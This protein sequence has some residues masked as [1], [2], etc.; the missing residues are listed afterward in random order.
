MTSEC[1]AGRRGKELDSGRSEDENF[2]SGIHIVIPTIGDIYSSC[3]CHYRLYESADY[4]PYSPRVTNKFSNR[5]I[6]RDKALSRFDNGAAELA[7]ELLAAEFAAAEST[8]ERIPIIIFISSIRC[9]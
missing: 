4:R 9:S 7:A 1:R 2:F 3:G 5:K 6:Y 8:G